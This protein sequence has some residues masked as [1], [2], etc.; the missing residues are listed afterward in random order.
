MARSRSQIPGVLFAS[1]ALLLLVAL[2]GCAGTPVEPDDPVDSPSAEPDPTPTETAPT[3]VDDTVLRITANVRS[4]TGATI[5]IRMTVHRALASDD[6]DAVELRDAF[7]ST[8]TVN[9]GGAPITADTLAASGA[10]LVRVELQ[11]T[12]NGQPF[13][14]PLQIYLNNQFSLLSATGTSIRPL[15]DDG[16]FSGYQWAGSDPATAIAVFENLDGRPDLTQWLYAVFG[17]SVGL[18]ADATI[19]ACQVTLVD[20]P[21]AEEISGWDPATAGTGKTCLIGYRGE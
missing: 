7:L 8:C 18:E 2:T 21:G 13:A 19:E 15:G 1:A 5:G 20:A 12:Q 10:T 4:D 3:P 17:F 16:C 6:A 11:S 9:A 14:A